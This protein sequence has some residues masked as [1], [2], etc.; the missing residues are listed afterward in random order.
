MDEPLK[1]IQLR[2]ANC[3]STLSRADRFETQIKCPYCGTVNEVTGIMN[4]E[5][6]APERIIPFTT[7]EDDFEQAICKFFVDQDYTVNDIFDRVHMENIA[8]VYLP[9]YLFE[10]KYEASYSCSVGYHET[11]NSGGKTRT[12]TRWQPASGTA[13]SNYAFLSLA[14]DGQ[15]IIPELAE[16]TKTFHY[17]PL[18]AQAFK[19]ELITGKGYQILPHNLDRETTW[20]KWGANAVEQLARQEAY[21]QLPSGEQIRDFK[22]T[23][24]Y[25]K[26]HDGRLFLAP[27]RFVYYNYEDQK[28]FVLFDGLGKN[29]HG[30]TPTDRKRYKT[31]KKLQLLGKWSSSAG[32]VLA[33]SVGVATSS[34]V[35]GAI[36]G[37]L[38]WLG[39]K[40]YSRFKV[41]RI[42]ENARNIRREAF[43]RIV[44]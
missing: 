5:V 27:F 31:V 22:S 25:D 28:Y 19:P 14:F 2:C 3:H 16:W 7:T 4:R 36:V 11:E 35:A 20:H 1:L 8:S 15:E 10:G 42:I 37:A 44:K 41:K 26:I 12:I 30:T 38:A 40:F 18:T 17:D 6:A 13:K 33:V 29:I 24:N 43:N 21:R 23:F 32:I 39:L 34:P 9:M